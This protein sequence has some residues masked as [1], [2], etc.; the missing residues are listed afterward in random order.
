MEEE[1]PGIKIPS[2]QMVSSG[3]IILDPENP[4]EMSKENFEALKLNI[5]R[6][7]FLVPVITNKEFKV[8][9]GEHRLKA[10]RDLGMSEIPTIVLPVDEVDRR[11]LRQVMN[12]LKGSHDSGKDAEDYKWLSEN[13]GLLDL[14]QLLPEE[15]YSFLNSADD[16]EDDSADLPSADD[17][18]YVPK[19][20]VKKGDRWILGNHHLICGDAT[21]EKYYEGL[22]AGH[23]MDLVLTDPPY[24]IGYEYNQHVDSEGTAYMAF[25]DKWFPLARESAPLM[26]LF[27]GWKYNLFWEQKEPYDVFYWIARNKQSGGKNSHWRRTEPIFMGRG[28]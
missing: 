23:E 15:D 20:E 2:I 3:R 16:I 10:G 4:N 28:S 12:K 22:L 21:E 27:A 14:Q 18:K 5:R 25:C 6:Y 7:G 11:I 1:K 26:I 17:E 24:G 9:D 19:Y 8:A 13:G